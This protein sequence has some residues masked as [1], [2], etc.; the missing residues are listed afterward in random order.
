MFDQFATTVKY[1]TLCNILFIYL[2]VCSFVC[3]TLRK[4]SCPQNQKQL[5]LYIKAVAMSSSP[6][7]SWSQPYHRV[8]WNGNPDKRCH[9]RRYVSLRSLKQIRWI[10]CFLFVLPILKE[11]AIKTNSTWN[12]TWLTSILRYVSSPQSDITTKST[13]TVSPTWSNIHYIM[14]VSV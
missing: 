7:S 2:F 6:S 11:S 13:V 3:L 1:L 9:E 5:N 12:P 4:T 14:T 8:E 10:V